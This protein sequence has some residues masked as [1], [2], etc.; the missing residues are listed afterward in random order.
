[1]PQQHRAHAT[2]HAIL[3]AAAEEFDRAGYAATPLSA[4]LR[5]SGVTKGAFYFHF[6]SKEALAAALV[7]AQEAVWPELYQRWVDRGLDPLRT[8]V[9]II[10]DLVRA[11]ATDTVVRAGLRLSSESRVVDNELPSPYPLW[12]RVLFEMFDQAAG[13]GLLREGV[14]PAVAARVLNAALVGARII[15]CSLNR[16]T[17]VVQRTREVWPLVLPGIAAEDW[18]ADWTGEWRH[19]VSPVQVQ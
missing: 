6:P 13:A 7:H 4:I 11:V 15:S 9:G 5:R 18:L 16:C 8:L 12:E 3:T 17:D 19:G 1:M 14:S 2:R 10:D